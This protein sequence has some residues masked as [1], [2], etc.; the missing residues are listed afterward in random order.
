[1]WWIIVSSVIMWSLISGS[2]GDSN[3]HKVT[4]Q[5]DTEE[6]E[7]HPA[8]EI[9][10]IN[11]FGNLGI[12]G[13][14]LE[15]DPF[16]ISGLNIQNSVNPLINITNINSF[17]E[18]SNSILIGDGT[19]SLGIFISNSSHII[20]QNIVVQNLQTGI[21]L[22]NSRGITIENVMISDSKVNAII[23][24]NTNNTL[25]S[26]SSLEN[27][28]KGLSLRGSNYNTITN[29][30][31]RNHSGYG[32]EIDKFSSNNLIVWNSFVDNNQGT[33]FLSQSKDDGI[34]NQFVNNFWNEL[35]YQDTNEDDNADLPY[36]IDGIANNQDQF[37]LTLPNRSIDG[38]NIVGSAVNDEAR[39]TP[40]ILIAMVLI[41]SAL[42][43][44][45][46]HLFKK[47]FRFA[48]EK[49]IEA[50][51]ISM[52]G[53]M[54]PIL[55]N[56]FRGTDD[57]DIEIDENISVELKQYKFILNPIRLSIINALYDL[58]SY[59]AYLLREMIRVSWGNFGSH[60]EALTKKGFIATRDEFIDGSVKQII[61]LED[62]GLQH[63]VELK[64]V[65]KKL[66]DFEGELD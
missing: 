53:F 19:A 65:L 54:P 39:V 49:L 50:S 40:T 57:V 6:Y 23:F 8:L 37:P 44:I 18:I 36:H 3:P 64:T 48:P 27:N 45:A 14:G 38:Y 7:T 59:P 9:N 22:R 35:T 34:S 15:N 21:I 24:E 2:T 66:F 52:I 25:I 31:L 60:I 58:H 10:H 1:M 56:V 26:K 43:A 63:Y 61:Y 11:D 20:I 32:L 55:T 4:A 28:V 33:G 51:F 16:L 42:I 46:N 13:S 41:I 29:N 17:V 12:L 30:I 5:P 62:L 47:F